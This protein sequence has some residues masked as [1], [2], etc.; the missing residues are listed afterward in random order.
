VGLSARSFVF[1]ASDSFG[2]VANA[3]QYFRAA[4]SPFWA[5]AA[6]WLTGIARTSADTH[7]ARSMSGTSLGESWDERDQSSRSDG[8][9]SGVGVDDSGSGQENA[10]RFGPSSVRPDSGYAGPTSGRGGS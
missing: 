8:I 1:S 6:A 4:F 3:C 7:N 9:A 2:M 5:S 10:G